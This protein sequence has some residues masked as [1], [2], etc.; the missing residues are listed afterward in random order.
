VFRL[1]PPGISAFEQPI[2]NIAKTAI[3]LLME[4][5]KNGSADKTKKQSQQILLEGKLIMRRST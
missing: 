1:Y 5:L 4:Q 2:A 3:A